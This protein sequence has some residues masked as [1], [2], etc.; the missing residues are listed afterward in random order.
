MTA[1]VHVAASNNRI[2]K[3]ITIATSGTG[4]MDA[5]FWGE[6][7]SVACQI[8][9]LSKQCPNGDYGVCPSFAFT[10]SKKQGRHN[11]WKPL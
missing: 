8:S 10:V 1:N 5:D 2:L 6:Y 11:Y 4:V 9:T 3:Q 7:V